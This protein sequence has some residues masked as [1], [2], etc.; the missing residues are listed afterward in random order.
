MLFRSDSELSTKL[1]NHV[2]KICKQVIDKCQHDDKEVMYWVEATLGEAELIQGNINEAKIFYRSAI[3]K[4]GNDMRGLISMHKQVSKILS[5]KTIN[6]DSFNI[7]FKKPTVLVFSG[8]MID[9]V[10]RKDERFPLASEDLVRDKIKD[11]LNEYQVCIAY[12]SAACGSDIIFLEE[13]LKKGG[14]INITLPYEIE[15]FKEQCV[16]FIPNLNWGERF[17]ALIEKDRKSVV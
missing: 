14:E 8:H 13:V 16:N 1:A 6:D 7:I 5:Y 12:S 2:A 9:S 4:I 17:D 10:G 3:N 15:S 11:I